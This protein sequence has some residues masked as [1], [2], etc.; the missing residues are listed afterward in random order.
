MSNVIDFRSTV[1]VQADK[2]DDD[3]VNTVLTNAKAEG[4]E[5]VL[6]MGFNK[7]GFFMTANAD[8]AETLWMI[9]NAKMVLLTGDAE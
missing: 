6:V 5:T 2:P 1:F 8:D 4:L 3:P 9:E 7:D